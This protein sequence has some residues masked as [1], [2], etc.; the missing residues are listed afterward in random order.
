MAEQ[1]TSAAPVTRRRAIVL[2]LLVVFFVLLAGVVVLLTSVWEDDVGTDDPL[3]S[4]TYYASS[5]AVCALLDPDDLELVLGFAFQEGFEPDAIYPAF[6]GTPGITRC[7]YLRGDGSEVVN[8]GVVYAYADQVF[9]DRVERYRELGEV[10]ELEGLGRRAV[11]I[12]AG[13]NLLVLTDDKV[14]GVIPPTGS[15]HDAIERARRLAEKAIER[16][17]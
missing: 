4:D 9:E 14:V 13:N 16:L 12:E 17:K 6:A 10:K 3:V 7:T 2:T 8:L 5:E 1:R 15:E 11:W